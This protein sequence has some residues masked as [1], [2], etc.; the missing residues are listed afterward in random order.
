MKCLWCNNPPEL[1]K[2]KCSSCLEKDRQRSRKKRKTRKQQRLC[3]YCQNKTNNNSVLC[4]ECKTKKRIEN[5]QKRQ[6]RKSK[7]LCPECGN[8]P[9]PGFVRCDNCVSK[10]RENRNRI[11]QTVIIGYGGICACCGESE[12]S[13]LQLDHVNTNGA[14]ERRIYTNSQSIYLKAI[15]DGFPS[16]YQLL[17]ANCNFGRHLNGGNCPHK[18]GGAA[19]G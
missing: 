3:K 8:K 1:G 11:R 16:E 14:E 7:G 15:R 5:T 18:T 2:R 12:P 4:G 10:Q 17:C 6:N 13:F 19:T 9:S